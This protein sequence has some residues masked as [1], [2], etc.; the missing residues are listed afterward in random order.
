M[1]DGTG[2]H[3]GSRRYP[4]DKLRALREAELRDAAVELGLEAESITFLR[5]R[6]RC[7][8][9]DGPAATA[10]CDAIVA[11][12]DDCSAGAV[13]VSWIHDPHS[14]HVASAK[15]ALKARPRL[16]SARLFY[17]PIW[18]WTLPSHTEVGRAPAGLRL[19]I[20]PYLEAKAAAVAAHRSQVTD[21]IDD[22]PNG[23]RLTDEMLANFN[24][25]YE[26]LLSVEREPLG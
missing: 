3:A 9:T 17:Y 18:G 24:R 21:L 15:L 14:D 22:D 19:D 20:T 10:A 16:G 5:L 8:P 6:D 2:S 7:V 13:C 25:P 12:A 11:A 4:A 23:F 26:I 1:S